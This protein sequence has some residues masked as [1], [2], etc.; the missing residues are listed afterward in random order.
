MQ[1][2]VHPVG[3]QALLAEVVDTAAA[4]RLYRWIRA[5]TDL[6]APTD[7]VP[8]ARTVLLDG[9]HDVDRWASELSDAEHA[10][11]VSAS[12]NSEA[13]EAGEV[14]VLPVEYGG[15]DLA[16]VA[17]EWGT[18]ES[19]VVRRHQQSRFT[20]AFCGFAPGFGYCTAT[21]PLPP[22]P[23]RTDP[24]PRVPAGAVALA[25]TYCGVYPRAMPGGWQVIGRTDATLFDP[26]R[27]PP[28]LLVPG[29]VVRF[30]EAE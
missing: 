14:V 22:V 25:D 19:A 7:V 16:A 4:Q 3:D 17:R 5:R 10:L 23:R 27:D 26:E 11:A 13:G 18:T 20:V 28:A 12:D 8:A 29:T 2:T 15:E 9:V 24:R 6:P 1:V 30:E 21:P